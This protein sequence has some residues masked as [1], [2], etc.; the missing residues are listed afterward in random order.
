VGLLLGA[1][2]WFQQQNLSMV[3]LMLPAHLGLLWATY[4]LGRNAEQQPRRAPPAAA[5][6]TRRRGAAVR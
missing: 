1:L 3:A 4:T 2:P 5:P 6:A